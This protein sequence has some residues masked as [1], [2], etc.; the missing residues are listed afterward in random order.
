VPTTAG[1]NADFG[2][3]EHLNPAAKIYFLYADTDIDLM[4]LGA[5]AKSARYGFDF[6]RNLGTNLEVHGE[7]S[8]AASATRPVVDSA[9]NVVPVEAPATS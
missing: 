6:S 7:W 2:T 9:G 1:L 4:M 3:S 5:G 8:R